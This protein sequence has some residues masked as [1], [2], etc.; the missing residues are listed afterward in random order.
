M[1][2][3]S[4]ESMR[5]V[6]TLANI[7]LTDDE[8]EQYSSELAIILD[9][10]QSLQDLNTDGIEPTG[11]AVDVNTVLREDKVASPMDRSQ[12]LGNVPSYSGD[13]VR[14]PPVIE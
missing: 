13:F 10:F 3:I 2:Q 4:N 11:H 6:A 5:E 1:D 12:V 14:I 9:H 7:K 8:L